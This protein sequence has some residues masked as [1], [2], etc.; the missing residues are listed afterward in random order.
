MRAFVFAANLSAQTADDRYPFVR[1][2]KLGFMDASGK[3]V[4]IRLRQSTA[5][6]ES[7]GRASDDSVAR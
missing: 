3:E 4:S 7:A 6:V 1:D 2:A 5:P